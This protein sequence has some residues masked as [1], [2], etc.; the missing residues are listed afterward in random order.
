[1]YSFTCLFLLQKLLSEDNGDDSDRA[2][3]PVRLLKFL[4]EDEKEAS[5]YLLATIQLLYFI[6]YYLV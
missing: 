2:E 4:R 5:Q 1:M 3:K 6:K